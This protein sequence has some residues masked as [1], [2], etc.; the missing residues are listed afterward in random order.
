[1]TILAKI[2]QNPLP[3]VRR[4]A[5]CDAAIS[6]FRRA[7]CLTRALGERLRQA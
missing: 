1:V 7:S 6:T 5:E 3:Y 2:A 4:L